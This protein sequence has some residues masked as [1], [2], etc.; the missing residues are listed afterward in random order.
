MA[1]KKEISPRRV[2]SVIGAK[3]LKIVKASRTVDATIMEKYLTNN[4]IFLVEYAWV[5]ER[6]RKKNGIG[7]VGSEYFTISCS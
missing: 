2:N 1:K 6:Q 3:N 7:D 5:Y 4:F